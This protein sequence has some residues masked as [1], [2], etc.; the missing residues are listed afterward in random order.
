RR[1]GISRRA[2]LR[3][4]IAPAKASRE[5]LDRRRG[6]W[7]VETKTER[8]RAARGQL[9]GRSLGDDPTAVEDRHAV[10]EVLGVAQVVRRQQDRPP[11]LAQ[12]RDQVA[13]GTPG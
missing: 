7:A 8:R 3:L 13:G 12:G 2:Q 4:V 9:V 5:R 1:P 6:R 10:R 11:L